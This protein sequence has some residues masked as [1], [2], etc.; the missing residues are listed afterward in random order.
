MGE[1]MIMKQVKA[2]WSIVRT[3]VKRNKTALLVSLCNVVILLV[4]SYV[5]NNQS[6]FTGENLNHYAWVEWVKNKVG[7]VKQLDSHDVLFVNIAYDKQLTERTDEYGMPIGNTSITDRAKL[8]SF[9]Q[10]LHS[11]D[12]YK[13]I[14]L[15][16]R[17][18]K[19]YDV[20]EVDSTLFA[21]IRNMRMI[22]IA[23]HSDVEIADSSLLEKAAI[24]DYKATITA[25]NFVRYKY[26][27]NGN[28]SMPL[29]AYRDLTKRTIKRH[30]LIYTCDG[31]LCY[32]SLFVN[33]PVEN[34][35]EFD[36]ENRKQYYNLGSDLLDNYSE[37]D[38]ATLTQGKYIVIGDMIEDL[39]DT[40]S[41]LKPGSVITYYAFQ[42]LMNRKH[43][44]SYSLLLFLAVL[45]FLISLS[46]F[47]QNSLLE[48]IPFVRKSHSRLLHF[49]LTFIGYTFL[50]TVVAIVLNIFADVSISILLPSTYFTI[51]KNI[52]NYKRT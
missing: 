16:V 46:Q 1:R 4:L 30:G 15:D 27:Y 8:L 2:I 5:L 49:V 13:Y 38:L 41:G 21:E 26:T 6:L 37:E 3:L 42:A 32:N 29:Y 22:V 43:F 24:S 33:F 45:Y 50:L 39:H 25:T 17:F 18:E 44:V 10:M 48:Q 9:L 40:Y 23:N 12:N 52:I 36:D 20:P 7:L 34:F 51:Q 47:R 35:S 31:R 28:P 11:T 19:G 14:F